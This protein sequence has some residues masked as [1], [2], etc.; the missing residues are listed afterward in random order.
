MAINKRR[1]K[2]EEMTTI[3]LKQYKRKAKAQRDNWKAR[4]V[5]AERCLKA[6]MRSCEGS[7]QCRAVMLREKECTVENCPIL[8]GIV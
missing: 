7:Y 2:D 6:H 5:L 3:E 8:E 1:R 4:A